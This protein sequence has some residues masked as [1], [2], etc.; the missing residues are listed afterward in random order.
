MKKFLSI[1]VLI[2]ISSC[3][4]NKSTSNTVADEK[5]KLCSDIRYNRLVNDFGPVEGKPIYKQNIHSLFE[6]LLLREGY[7]TEVSKTG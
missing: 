1:A 4:S 5:F 6:N 7:L 3:G 2:L